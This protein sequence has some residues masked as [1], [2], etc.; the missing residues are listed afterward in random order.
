MT[1]KATRVVAPPGPRIGAAGPQRG[2][3][4]IG[5]YFGILTLAS[6]LGHPDGL[7]RLPIQFWLKDLLGASPH[8][9]QVGVGAVEV[10]LLDG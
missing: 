5:F 9:S 1:A 10:G 4:Q 8:A 3:L 6:G 7:L 2:H